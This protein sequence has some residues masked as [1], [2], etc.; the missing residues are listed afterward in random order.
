MRKYLAEFHLLTV[1]LW[2]VVEIAEL[3]SHVVKELAGLTEA[4]AIPAVS[5]S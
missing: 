2:L 4:L 1:A 3:H 5:T